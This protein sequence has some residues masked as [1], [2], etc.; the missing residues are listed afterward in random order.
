MDWVFWKD[1]LSPGPFD[2]YVGTNYA[3]VLPTS[4]QPVKWPASRQTRFLH[5]GF[6]GKAAR[7]TTCKHGEAACYRDRRANAVCRVLPGLNRCSEFYKEL[8][9]ESVPMQRI[10]M[11]AEI[12]I[13]ARPLPA[14]MLRMKSKGCKCKCNAANKVRIC[15][16][17]PQCI[18][19][20]CRASAKRHYL[21]LT[22]TY[23]WFSSVSTQRL[24]SLVIGSRNWFI[25]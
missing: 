11:S 5:L 8:H 12:N 1:P 14:E 20:W 19:I 22:A 9:T 16:K 15:M 7:V 13:L 23:D 17:L 10:Q 2:S 24:C 3:G 4:I 25:Y 6:R 21:W 18:S